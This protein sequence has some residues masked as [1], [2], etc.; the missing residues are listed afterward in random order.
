[1]EPSPN[2]QQSRCTQRSSP[3]GRSRCT[4]VRSASSSATVWGRFTRATQSW[5][6]SIGQALSHAV[7]FGSQWVRRQ[8]L[9]HY[10]SSARFTSF[11]HKAFRST[12]RVTVKKYSLPPPKGA[13]LAIQL[14]SRLPR[15]ILD[16]HFLHR[17]SSPRS[18]ATSPGQESARG[19][20]ARPLRPRST[21]CG[22]RGLNRCRLS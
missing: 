13:R 22:A 8:R 10:Q 19:H 11:A 6:S 21:C 18:S 17:I 4:Q 15:S 7:P 14:Y 2:R 12:Y 20:N 9:P 16:L 5:G 1:M 3:N